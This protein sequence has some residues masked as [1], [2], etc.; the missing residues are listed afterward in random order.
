MPGGE[1][2]FYATIADLLGDKVRYEVQTHQPAVE[3]EFSGALVEA[4]QLPGRRGPGGED[5]AYDERWTDGKAWTRAGIRCLGFP[6]YACRPNWTSSACSTAW[7]SGCRSPSLEF[8]AR[9]LD[10]L[11]S[12]A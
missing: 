2:E 7:T 4:M 3:T 6:R 10:R 9:V 1:D 8:G 11:L 12:E 5:G